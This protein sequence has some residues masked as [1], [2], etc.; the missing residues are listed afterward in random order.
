MR[1]Q[2]PLCVRFCVLNAQ[3]RKMNNDSDG[4]GAVEEAHPDVNSGKAAKHASWL[5]Q[6]AAQIVHEMKMSD[7]KAAGR[8]QGIIRSF[9]AR[10]KLQRQRNAVLGAVATRIQR[11]AR[12]NQGS[13]VAGPSPRR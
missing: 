9:I 8:L 13:R 6:R 3:G 10:Q 5:A 2:T 1:V 4:V 11:V 7:T 12:G